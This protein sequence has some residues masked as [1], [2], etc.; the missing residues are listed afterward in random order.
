V[1]A[2]VPEGA[3]VDPLSDPT[4]ERRST[5]TARAFGVTVAVRVNDS[6]L[7]KPLVARLP[8]GSETIENE[9]IDLQYS[10]CRSRLPVP[11]DPHEAQSRYVVSSGEHTG[12]EIAEESDALDFF[13]SMVRFDIAVTA[14][15][16]LFVHA[17]VVGWQDRA[18]VIPAQSMHGK[19]QLVAALVSAGA[20]YYS[21]EYAVFDRDGRVHPFRLAASLREPD[22]RARRV[23]LA[24]SVDPRPLPVGFV[25]ATRYEPGTTWEPRRGTPGEAAMALLANTVRARIAPAETLRVLARAAEHA[26]LLEGPRGEAGDTTPSLLQACGSNDDP[27]PMPAEKASVSAPPRNRWQ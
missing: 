16:W 12:V 19:S 8:P 25:V 23:V 27:S 18:I 10:V 20:E 3:T 21:D 11:D 22:G 15:D 6:A 7:L 26:I 24:T 9:N 4:S 13:E 17:G 14:S 2:G 5:V 1:K